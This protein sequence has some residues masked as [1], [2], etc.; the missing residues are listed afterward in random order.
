MNDLKNVMYL[1]NGIIF[2]LKKERNPVIC[3][4]TDGSG[5]HYLKRN[6]LDREKQICMIS[7]I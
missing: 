5:E 7:F 6:K 1:Y 4:S 3:D 2:S